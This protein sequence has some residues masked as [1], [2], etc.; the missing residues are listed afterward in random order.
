MGTQWEVDIFLQRI[1]L[2]AKKNHKNTSIYVYIC[3]S[4]TWNT[5]LP[6]LTSFTFAALNVLVRRTLTAERPKSWMGS[7]AAG[8]L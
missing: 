5:H 4:S 1:F 6:H 2:G 3:I 7:D 8:G